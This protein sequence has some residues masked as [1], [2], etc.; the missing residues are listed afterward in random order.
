MMEISAALQ[1]ILPPDRI[2]TRLIDLLSYASDAGFYHLQP[3]AVVQVTSEKEIADRIREVANQKIVVSIA[4]PLNETYDGLA[5]ASG[6]SA[7]QALQE[8]LPHSKIIK[9][10]NTTFAADFINP[11]IDNKQVD[12]F[13]AGNDEEALQA[14][15]ELVSTAG[16]NPI[17]AGD[18]SVSETLERMQLLLVQLGIKYNYNWHAGWKVLHN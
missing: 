3:K 7:A 15:S 8:Q 6:R 13:I 17:I 2:K 12:A 5:V 11:V 9:A 18:L 14:V 1:N 16:F 10:F 4:N